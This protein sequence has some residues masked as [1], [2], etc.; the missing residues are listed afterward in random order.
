M[1]FEVTNIVVLS[2]GRR[3]SIITLYDDF[4][5]VAKKVA[6]DMTS[7]WNNKVPLPLEIKIDKTDREIHDGRIIRIEPLDEC[8]DEEKKELANILMNKENYISTASII[9]YKDSLSDEEQV[10]RLKELWK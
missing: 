7:A 9:E 10:E 8:N 6:R 2:T 4:S 1:V 5:E 3:L